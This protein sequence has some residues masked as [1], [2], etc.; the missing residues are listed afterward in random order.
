MAVHASTTKRQWMPMIE[1][2]AC[3]ACVGALFWRVLQLIQVATETSPLFTALYPLT[4][5]CSLALALPH[6]MFLS[7]ADH[8]RGLHPAW[9]PHYAFL[10]LR[11]F[12]AALQDAALKVKSKEL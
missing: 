1:A 11:L 8:F 5:L 3:I 7:Y 10:T 12:R 6:L 9:P 4:A 2:A